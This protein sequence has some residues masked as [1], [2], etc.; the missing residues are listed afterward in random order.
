[1]IYEI[2]FKKSALKDLLNFP[3]DDVK[4]IISKI[5]L[6]AVD[7]R[8][9]GCK[10]LHG[11]NAGLWRI[12]VGNYRVL[13]IIEDIIKVVEINAVGHRKDIY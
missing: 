2:R 4:H 11:E 1:M 13:Y 12:R 9:I 10:K 7:P 3:S 8:P 5:D 6:L